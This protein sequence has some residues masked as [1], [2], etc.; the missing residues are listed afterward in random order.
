MREIVVAS[1]NIGKIKEIK[2]IF[3]DFNIIGLGEVEITY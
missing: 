2:D 3:S 1:N